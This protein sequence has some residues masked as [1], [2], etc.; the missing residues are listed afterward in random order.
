MFT[1]TRW[2]VRHPWWT[3]VLVL[4]VTAVL[5]YQIRTIKVDPDITSALPQDIPAKRLYDRMNEI[6]PSRD[7]ILIA[8]ESDSLFS[9]E[10]IQ[11]LYRITRQLEDMPDVY[12]VMSPTNVKVIRGTESGMEVREILEEPPQTAQEVDVY[13]QTL[14][15]SDLPIE[16]LISR[17]GRMAGIMVFLKNTIKPEDAAD[18]ILQFF[19]QQQLPFNYYITGKPVL[20]YYLGRGMARDMGILFPLVILIIIVILWISFRSF[21][22]VLLPL[23]IVISSVICTIG[24][25]AIFGV[26]ISHSTN[27][28]PILLA[29]IAV[30]DGIHILNRYFEHAQH[31]RRSKDTVLAV[32]KELNAPV[33]IT[34]I[35]TSF[36]FLAL[37]TS[38]VGSVGE[39]GIFTA[40]GVMIAMVFSLT[41]LPATLSLLK[42]PE[43]IREHKRRSLLSRLAIGYANLLIRHR[44]L[45]MGFV[46]AVVLFA[47]LGFPQIHLENNTISNFPEDHPARLAFEKVNQ[48]FA[49]TTFL[50]V[51]VE[52]DSAGQIKE[53][54]VLRDMVQL[55]AFLKSLPHVGATLSIADFI[56]RM[57]KVMHADS[58]AYNR[59]PDDTV[60][61]IG[62]EWVERNGRWVEVPVKFKVPGRE[63]VAQYLQLYEMSSKPD[64]FAN[65]VDYQ[66][67][68]ARINAFIDTESANVL[69]EIE[70]KTRAFIAE[71]FHSAR[72]EL[73]GTSQLFLAIN[74]LVVGGQFWSILASLF[75]VTLVTTLS[76]R[77]VTIGLFNAIP[78]LFAMIFNFGFMGWTGTYLNIVTMLT[79]SIAIG[80]GVDYAVHFIHRYQ[81]ELAMMSE[82]ESLR[83]TMVEAGV[84]IVL[85]ALT[86]GLGFAVMMFSIFAGVQN[87]GM[88]ITLAMFTTCFGAITI[89]PVIFLTFKPQVLK[90][91][92][93][94]Q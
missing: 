77:S 32:M 90:K 55:E 68:T 28:L 69:R 88:L 72:V 9:V 66:Y 1:I 76:F 52:G 43:K 4:A 67:Q 78:L 79:S 74:D 37:N 2:V 93:I 64:D 53:P 86:V 49:G 80:V 29:S 54:R 91:K 70:Q 25:M 47:I 34:S 41:F 19:E 24:L 11:H 36:G 58:E 15:H 3:I 92:E 85:N 7:F 5:G 17:D 38:H 14:F 13:R 44:P 73:T 20:T 23:F 40:V 60:E 63:L 18:Q 6:F 48:N 57:N 71:N 39:L 8:I 62:Y 94:P 51:M 83:V 42:I 61:A 46:I 26:P 10:V 89:L 81:M 84:P 27:M 75:L 31:S 30:A 65:L 33:I 82:E 22:G 59:I 56:K 87:M 21:R 35:T 45:A 50:A 16:N 12:T